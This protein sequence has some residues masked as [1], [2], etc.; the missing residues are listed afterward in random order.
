MYLRNL[1]KAVHIVRVGRRKARTRM[2]ASAPERTWGAID[3]AA[4]RAGTGF[5]LSEVLDSDTA[6]TKGG[7]VFACEGAALFGTIA[8][9][10]ELRNGRTRALQESGV[11]RPKRGIG[12]VRVA[13]TNR[14]GPGTTEQHELVNAAAKPE[15]CGQRY[16]YFGA[17]TCDK[18]LLSAV[19]EVTIIP[20]PQK[21]AVSYRTSLQVFQ[22][23][24][25]SGAERKLHKGSVRLL[26]ATEFVS[27]KAVYC[28]LQRTILIGKVHD[29]ERRAK[30]GWRSK[31]SRVRREP[32]DQ[33]KR[34]IG[35]VRV[36]YHVVAYE[37]RRIMSSKHRAVSPLTQRPKSEKDGQ[38]YW[39]FGA[40]NCD[41]ASSSF[42]CKE[43]LP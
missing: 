38:R 32:V 16:F 13:Y 1:S 39:C 24:E 29:A 14:L 40:W 21:G 12:C 31:N 30:T 33:P 36:V 27:M 4:A 11:D 23:E 8:S 5:N 2:F 25:T 35:C 18:M 22:A 37:L 42:P 9:G 7:R 10:R 26:E 28:H 6:G 15:K 34:G 3:A 43:F 41:R 17:L 20:G 19:Q